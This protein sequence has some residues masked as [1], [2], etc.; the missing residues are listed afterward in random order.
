MRIVSWNV[1]SIRIRIDLLKKLINTKSP[2]VICIQEVKAKEEDFPYHEIRQ[3][4]YEYIAL[5]GMP[6]YNGVSILSKLPINNIKK[7]DWCNKTD[8]RHISATVKNIEIHNIYVPA[9]GDVPD[10]KTNPSFV[11]KLQF[12]DE[13][14]TW[15]AS[16]KNEYK[17]KNLLICG[18][19]NIAMLEHDVWDHKK[20]LKIISHTPIEI[21][22][23]M[24][25]YNSIDFRDIIREK[26]PEPEKIY[27]WWSYRNPNWQTNNKGRRL[28]Y[29]W[30]NPDFKPKIE[31][32]EILKEF[33]SFERPSD[34]VP[35]LV[36]LEA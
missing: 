14:T 12:V 22:K 4:G 3:L 2:D 30:V 27:S 24:N 11:H 31:N 15:F 17:D 5:Y 13:L 1:N 33:R 32:I 23:L 10:I 20:M 21:E 6:G 29:I 28:D 25:L 8:A 35:L 36:E 9:G 34:H 18:D 16:Y 7:H 19:F 26:F